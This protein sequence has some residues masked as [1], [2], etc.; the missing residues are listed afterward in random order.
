MEDI[1]KDCSKGNINIMK[2]LELTA[3]VLSKSIFNLVKML[4][5]MKTLRTSLTPPVSLP[6]IFLNY[7]TTSKV[8]IIYTMCC[9]Y[10]SH[11]SDEGV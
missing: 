2:N 5:K 6:V 11:R 4:T 1:L 8:Y 7:I 10:N 9:H 3:L